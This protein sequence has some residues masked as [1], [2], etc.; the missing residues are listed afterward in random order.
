MTSLDLCHF[1][2]KCGPGIII[3][4]ILK[5]KKKNLFMLGGYPFNNILLYLT[6]G[7][8]E[9]IYDKEQLVVL[10]N[11]HVKHRKYNFTFNHEYI[12]RE[13]IQES[14]LANYDVVR[15]RFDIK[16]MNFKKMLSADNMCVFITFTNNLE[17]LKLTEMLEWL[18]IH[19]KNFHL[20]I[21]TNCAS[22][23]TN[24][25]KHCSIL[26]LSHSYEKWHE[27]DPVTKR[28]LYTE[29]YDTFIKCLHDNA[30]E[31]T[32]PMNIEEGCKLPKW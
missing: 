5:T 14:K 18:T 28:I 2:D 1:G 24:E 25:L 17:D 27:M 23:S 29:I 7:D 3:D 13:S 16:I 6:D 8:Y 22:T 15:S 12:I 9:S 11:H 4:D 31:H 20:M 21:F 32:F 26:R 19:K 10:P 30:I